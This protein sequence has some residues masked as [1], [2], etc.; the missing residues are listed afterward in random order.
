MKGATPSG[1]IERDDHQRDPERDALQDRARGARSRPIARSPSRAGTYWI[2]IPSAIAASTPV[3]T[4]GEGWPQAVKSRPSTA[5]ASENEEARKKTQARQTTLN[6]TSRRTRS[7]QRG[8]QRLGEAARACAGRAASARSTSAGAVDPAPHHEGPG[9]AV[10][11]AAEEH[12]QH[13]VQVRARRALPVAA[14]RDVEVVAQPRAR[15]SCASAAR[16][17][18]SRRAAYGLLKFCGKLEAEQQRD[19]DRDV[20]VAGRSRRRSAPRRRRC[21]RAP[22]AT[23]AGRAPRTPRPR[24]ARRGSWRSRP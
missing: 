7:A 23:S 11:E 24:S 22:R 12:R 13:Q 6:V 14:E 18:G 1:P 19:A 5:P 4:S 3:V 10:P 8:V 9:R 15:A 21:R 16:S 20:R 2:P 17:P